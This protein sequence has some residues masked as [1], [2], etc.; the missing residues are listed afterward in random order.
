M[1]REAAR[2]FAR[3]EPLSL[4]AIMARARGFTERFWHGNGLESGAFSL[5]DLAWTLLCGI[6]APADYLDAL[7]RGIGSLAQDTAQR[8]AKAEALRRG[9]DHPDVRHQPAPQGSA[10]W[11]YN[12]LAGRDRD[13]LLA[14]LRREGIK[15]SAYF[16]PC[17]RLFAATRELDFPASEREG[18]R[19]VNL[20]VGPQTSLAETGRIAREIVRFFDEIPAGEATE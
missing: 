8:Q 5:D 15:A 16:G 3:F 17:H 9:L 18:S 6:E 20:W 14:H 2:L 10:Y 12:I 7:N 19:I 4:D 11:R 1:R 13:R